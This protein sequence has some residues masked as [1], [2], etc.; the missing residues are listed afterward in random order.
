MGTKITKLILTKQF[1][2]RDNM[3]DRMNALKVS[4]I[5]NSVCQS[6]IYREWHETMCTA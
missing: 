3:K 4:E 2:K 6:F 5:T 1:W